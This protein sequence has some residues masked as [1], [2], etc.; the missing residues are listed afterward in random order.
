MMVFFYD[1]GLLYSSK[2]P[3]T[4]KR[5]MRTLYKLQQNSISHVKKQNKTQN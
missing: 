1:R 5:V 4:D 3:L 2:L